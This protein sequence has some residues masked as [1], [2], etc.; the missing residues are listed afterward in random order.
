MTALSSA[1]ASQPPPPQ[2]SAYD[3]ALAAATALA[4]ALTVAAAAAVLAGIFAAAKIRETALRAALSVV[5]GMPPGAEGFYGPATAQVARLNLIRRAQFLVASS[6]RFNDQMILIASGGADPQSVFDMMDA[7]RRYYG[8]HLEA[9]RNRMA[10]AAQADSAAM[11]YGALLGWYTRIDARTSP[12]CLAADKHN[13]RVDAMPLI[14]FPGAVHL[15]CRCF[16]GPPF[17]GASVLPA[18][19]VLARGRPV[20]DRGH[21]HRTAHAGVHR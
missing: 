7:E 3:L 11:D 9:G 1:Q 10:A 15:H 19:S 8:L 5:M 21:G 20:P 12:E 17:P 14:G 13:F 4:T 2:P 18:A 16:P 6:R